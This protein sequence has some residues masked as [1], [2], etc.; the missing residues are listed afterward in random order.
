MIPL[1]VLSTA[2]ET[3][4]NMPKSAHKIHDV[5]YY[6]KNPDPSA[7]GEMADY[8]AVWMSYDD[9]DNHTNAE[10]FVLKPVDSEE[11]AENTYFG[12]NGFRID[13]KWYKVAALWTVNPDADIIDKGNGKKAVFTPLY[14]QGY[15]HL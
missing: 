13:G 10:V 9:P 1:S 2:A 3:I 11:E 12:M 8:P 14:Y 15:R 5:V 7:E 6:D 4:E